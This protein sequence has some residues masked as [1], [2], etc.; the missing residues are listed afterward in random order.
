MKKIMKFKDNEDYVINMTDENIINIIGTKGSG[1]T[2]TSLKYIDDD[3]Y[4][5]VNCDK[6]FDMPENIK[7]SDEFL[8]LKNY[9]INKFGDLSK[10]ED[11]SPVYNS[12]I[13]YIIDKGK[14]PI[15]EGNIIQDLPIDTIRGKIIVKRTAVFKSFYR[16]VKRDYKNDYFMKLEKE[17]HKY[18]YKFTRLKKITKRRLKI[19]NQANNINEY[20][21]SYESSNNKKSIK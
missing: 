20:I 19:F 2:T 9:I 17:S 3:N 4:L 10:V 8:E 18:L 5:I 21:K 13:N 12:I 15:I 16:A 6:L 14:V 1:K 7:V 11:F